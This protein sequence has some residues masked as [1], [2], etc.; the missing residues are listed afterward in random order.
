MYELN[1]NSKIPLHYQLY[2]ALK[3]DIIENLNENDKLPSIR[4]VATLYNISKNTVQTA[5]SQLYAEGYI[6]SLPKSAYIVSNIN[7]ENLEFEDKKVVK[8]R[9]KKEYSYNFAPSKLHKELFPLKIFKKLMNKAINHEID[10]GTYNDGQ[11][12]ENLRK[13]ILKYLN[14]SR[15]VNAHFD[16]IVV[17]SGFSESMGILAKLL[18]TISDSFAI[19]N[20]GYF[21]AKEIFESFNYKIEKIDVDKNGIDIKILNKCSSKIVYVTPSHQYPKGVS[22]PISNR[23]EL[24]KWANTNNAIIIEDDYDSELNYVNKPIPS[25]QG[26]DRN[27]KVV[28]LGTFS[29]SLSPVLRISYMV[30]PIP[31]AIEYQKLFDVHFAKVSLPLQKTMELFLK[32][33]FYEKH[34]RKVRAVNKRKHDLM[35]NYLKEYLKNSFKFEND[36]AGLNITINPIVKFDFNKFKQLAMEEKMNIYFASN[37][38]GGDWEAIRLGFGG[39]KE[40]EIQGAIKAFSIIWEKSIIN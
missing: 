12:E 1:S 23:I 35:K 25:L 5:Y 30:L 10:F 7:Y 9:E 31:L 34:L 2:E 40:D 6:E 19:E 26:L 14:T 11:G 24:L 20:P 3:K 15:G 28:Y 38:S 18:K 13:E 21:I 36:G 33:G 8:I 22:M 27:E 37:T 4:K 16:Q 29:K 32:E 17:T 39:F